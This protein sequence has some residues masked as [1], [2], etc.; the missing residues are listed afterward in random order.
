MKYCLD[1]ELELG[2]DELNRE[3]CPIATNQ[4]CEHLFHYHCLQKLMNESF[5]FCPF[6]SSSL[7][8]DSIVL[9]DCKIF[10]DHELFDN[11]LHKWDPNSKESFSFQMRERIYYFVLSQSVFLKKSSLK[12]PKHLNFLIINYFAL[13]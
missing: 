6:C 9:D 2:I 7:Y 1:C 3:S 12:I 10:I 13:S 5:Q 11:S 4:N 8:I